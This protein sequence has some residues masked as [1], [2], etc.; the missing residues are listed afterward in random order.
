MA[1]RMLYKVVEPHHN[2]VTAILGK[3]GNVDQVMSRKAVPSGSPVALPAGLT[4]HELASLCFNRSPQV[5]ME[6]SSGQV[7]AEQVCTILDYISVVDN[8]LIVGNKATEASKLRSVATSLQTAAAKKD[9]EEMRKVVN[10]KMV[11]AEELLSGPVAKLLQQIHN[12][13]GAPCPWAKKDDAAYKR[14]IL[15]STVC[16]QKA[17]AWISLLATDVLEEVRGASKVALA[18]PTKDSP[19][20]KEMVDVAT[21]D[22]KAVDRLNNN[23]QKFHGVTSERDADYFYIAATKGVA[24][25]ARANGCLQELISLCQHPGLSAWEKGGPDK[26]LQELF[27]GL[28]TTR[29][30]IATCVDE[31][32]ALLVKQLLADLIVPGPVFFV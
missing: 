17:V 30:A 3:A 6:F 27:G 16:Q 5:M 22:A 25:S 1:S 24:I 2:F 18:L 21:Q 15:L 11:Q 23:P 29:K 8:I 20:L 28:L 7:S 9:T 12:C 26:E 10:S 4:A 14:L 19:L 31:G 32:E 13:R